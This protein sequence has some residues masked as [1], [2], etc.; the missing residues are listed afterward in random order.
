MS[1][2]AIIPARGGS[3]GV[4]GKN[5]RML[6]GRPLIQYS[7]E[8]A[9]NAASVDE[10]YVT[11]DSEAIGEVASMSGANVIARPSDLSGDN[12]SSESAIL[13]ALGDIEKSTG[14]LPELV[15]FM[16]CTSPLREPGDIDKA[17][18]YFRSENANSLLSVVPNHR[19][20]WSDQDGV[21]SA[22]NYDPKNRPRRQD[23][24]PQY[25]ENGSFYIFDAA[26]FLAEKNRLFG[27]TVVYE[28]SSDSMLEIDEELDFV[29]IEALMNGVG[30]SEG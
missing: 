15:V 19:F 22:L 24:T 1:V 8:H 2:V 4:P 7:I 25:M 3:K 10:V 11:S 21:V 17:L 30:L 27:K 16:Q 5:I 12:A 20:I 26:R 14:S 28:M 29:L 18:E 6:C 13:H 9:L 23:M